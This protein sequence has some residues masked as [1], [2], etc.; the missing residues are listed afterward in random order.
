MGNYVLRNSALS[1]KGQSLVFLS[2]GGKQV[3]LLGESEL[4]SKELTSIVRLSTLNLSCGP[5]TKAPN[6]FDL[7]IRDDEGPIATFSVAD[8]K[9]VDELTVTFKCTQNPCVDVTGPSSEMPPIVSPVIY[10]GSVLASGTPP[11]GSPLDCL[12]QNAQ[13]TF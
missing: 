10:N 11:L 4:F 13:A 5:C 9:R 1:M 12:F 6:S 7:C 2:N 8:L 3:T